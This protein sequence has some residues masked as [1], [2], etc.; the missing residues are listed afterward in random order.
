MILEFGLGWVGHFCPHTQIHTLVF[1][2]YY[3]S[4]LDFVYASFPHFIHYRNA[5]CIIK[6][7]IDIVR[8]KSYAATS[9]KQKQQ[10]R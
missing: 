7:V 8:K 9:K 4:Y 2:Y 6:R 1:T 5:I 3:S 10:Q